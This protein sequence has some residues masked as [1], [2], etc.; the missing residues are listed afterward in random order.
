MDF[1]G[2]DTRGRLANA[3]YDLAARMLERIS[4]LYLGAGKP[5]EMRWW[6]RFGYSLAGTLAFSLLAASA[7]GTGIWFGLHIGAL[8]FSPIQGPQAQGVTTY[9]GG[10]LAIFL[11]LML[12]SVVMANG[13]KRGGP[14]R[15]FMSG[16][17]LL[18]FLTGVA[19]VAVGGNPVQGNTGIASLPGGV[20]PNV[21]TIAPAPVHVPANSGQ[22]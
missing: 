4:D 7:G 12:L 5:A 18:A 11:V 14:M 8:P 6:S 10:N 16:F 13:L 22:N 19:S 9:S 3:A 21:G 1:N 15:F 17:L 2:K 20:A